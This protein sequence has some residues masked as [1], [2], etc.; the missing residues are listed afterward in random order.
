MPQTTEIQ[1]IVPCFD[2]VDS[3]RAGLDA[4]SRFEAVDLYPRDGSEALGDIERRVAN[5]AGVSESD[6]LAYTSGMSAV[7]DSIDIALHASGK[8]QPTLAFAR[9]TYTQT[10]RYVENFLRGHR[11]EIITFD[12]GD[13]ASVQRMVEEKQPD[14]IVTESVSNFVN[15]PVLDTDFLLECIRAQ[16]KDITL[17]LDNTLPLSTALPIGE[18][19]TEEDGIIVVE[20]GTKSYTFNAELFGIGYTKNPALQD[21][22]KRYRRTRGTLPATQSLAQITELL[23]SDRES[24][25]ERNLRLFKNTGDI[26][27]RLG[28]AAEGNYDFQFSHPILPDHDNHERYKALFP[29]GGTPVFYI[30]SGKFDQYQVAE[31][32][33]AHPGVREQARL[34]QSFGFDHTRIVA[35]E[36]VGAVRIAGGANTDGIFLGDAIAESLYG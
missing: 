23:P 22:L 4:K 19:I 5:L 8:E 32:L 20:S 14:V 36:N 21:L 11:A 2:S 16:D 28:L 29:E 1:P 26:A 25:D 9:E 7:T 17:V 10:K 18:R 31:K 33:W 12:S 34:G 35:D 30:Q 24:F 27:V 13:N 15:V 6:V 3:L